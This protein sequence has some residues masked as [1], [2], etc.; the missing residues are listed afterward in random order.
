MHVRRSALDTYRFDASFF[1]EKGDLRF[2]N[3]FAAQ[4]FAAAAEGIARP[5][6]LHAMGLLHEL[7]HGML[8]LYRRTV[9]PEV[10]R[11]L[12]SK[13]E[14]ELGDELDRTLLA[15]VEEFPPPAVYRGEVTPEKFLAG[16]TENTPN[17]EHV[18]EELLLLYVA[19]QNPAYEP[20]RSLISDQRLKTSTAYVEVVRGAGKI[21]EDQPRFGPDRQTLLDLLLEPIRRA[22]DSLFDQLELIRSRWGL[23][24]GELDALLKLLLSMD[25][26]RE[27]GLW[28]TRNDQ[29]GGEPTI[30]A[31]KFSGEYYEHEPEQFSSDLHWM[32]RVVMIAKSTFVWLDQLSKKYGRNISTLDNIPEEEIRQLGARGFTALWLIGVWKRSAASQTIK[33]LQGNA[34]ALASAYSLHDYDIASEL[35]GW[36][37]LKVL[38]QRAQKY[39]IRLASDMV[40]NH[41]GLDSRWV[42]EHPH[43]FVQSEHPPFPGYRFEGPNLGSHP[44]VVIQL[45]EGYWSKNDAAVVFKRYDK[46]SGETKYIYHGNDGTTMPWND[47]AQL[48]YLRADVREAVYQTILHVARQF[49]IIRFDAA[50]TLAKKHYQR[51]WFPLPGTGGAI[52]SRAEH[53]LAKEKFDELFPV[54]FWRE[55]VDRMTIEAPNTLLLAEAFWMM[56]GY[57]VRTLGMH[58]VYNSAFMNMLK[59]EDNSSYRLSI[60]N[61]LEFNPQILKRYV[62]FMNNPDEEPAVAQFGKDG[63]YFGVCVLLSTMPGLPMFGHGQVEGF[64]E[65][66]GMEYSRAKHDEQ[67][68]LGLVERHEREIFPLLKKRYLFSEVENFHLYDFFAPEGH[69][70]EDVF[71]YTNRAGGE[72][73]LVVY[74]NKYKETRGWVR[75]SVGFLSENGA[76]VL[77]TLVEALQLSRKP[78]VLT[79]LR[80]QIHGLDYLYRNDDLA[81]RGLPLHLQAFEYR[82]FWDIREVA[83]APRR[84]WAGLER[85][86]NGRGVPSIDEALVEVTYRALHQPL[87]EAI[88][89]GSASYLAVATKTEAKTVVREK[90]QHILDGLSWMKNQG[91]HGGGRGVPKLEVVADNLLTALPR[92]TAKRTAKEGQLGVALLFLEATSEMIAKLAPEEPLPSWRLERPLAR[93]LSDAGVHHDEAARTAAVVLLILG[94]GRVERNYKKLLPA[95]LAVEAVQAHLEVHEHGGTAWFNK[96][97][98]EEL[99]HVLAIAVSATPEE[100]EETLALATKTGYRFEKLLAELDV[101]APL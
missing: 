100:S 94:T 79:V 4:R 15:F 68:D 36:D 84:P 59:K 55:V 29:G 30:E 20:V 85:E 76:I 2:P 91:I 31:P 33:Q 9:E 18:F 82:V 37:A 86:L 13:L 10:Y 95:L 38:E 43:W 25:L 21:L 6:E 28:F 34:E 78:E 101:S 42:N 98:F 40:P 32:P 97:R 51:L 39:G 58:R 64:G 46:R 92:A 48:N 67:I 80:D 7:F 54:E 52:P 60:R 72:R 69:V 5:A 63:K 14:G 65:K 70:D 53:A 12:L 83:D 61:V 81:E 73:A 57:F 19:N 44:D 27:E 3:L 90:L 87:Y 56:E 35:G 71:V 47:T 11:H 93:A 49:P 74:H 88:N 17:R 16:N 99:E 24:L 8:H 75:T 1:A 22:P 45:E 26:I 66:Y 23:Q 77:T 89:A 50:M 41:M 62:N 96:E